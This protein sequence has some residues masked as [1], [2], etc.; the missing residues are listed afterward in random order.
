MTAGLARGIEIFH[1]FHR[2]VLFLGVASIGLYVLVDNCVTVSFPHHLPRD[3][4]VHLGTQDRLLCVTQVFIVA[5]VLDG[6]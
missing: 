2:L 1:I 6:L 3:N 5:R 4:R